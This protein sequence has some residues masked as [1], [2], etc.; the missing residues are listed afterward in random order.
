MTREDNGHDAYERLLAFVADNID[1]YM[2]MIEECRM[3][4]VVESAFWVMNNIQMYDD[5][6][7]A[8]KMTSE[9]MLDALWYVTFD[10]DKHHLLFEQGKGMYEVIGA[11]LEEDL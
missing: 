8:H 1:R 11:A 4:D 9:D 3:A 10:R 7:E 5:C 2:P 6:D